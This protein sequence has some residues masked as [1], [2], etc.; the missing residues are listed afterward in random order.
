MLESV[1][2]GSRTLRSYRGSPPINS[3]L[4][5]SVVTQLNDLGVVADWRIIRG[6]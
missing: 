1:D 4:L 3:E 6:P 2:I 5:R